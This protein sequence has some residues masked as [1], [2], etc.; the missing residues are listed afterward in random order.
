MREAGDSGKKMDKM[1]STT[2]V[3]RDPWGLRGARD[4]KSWI[5]N[6]GHMH[7]EW[8]FV[9]L[10]PGYVADRGMRLRV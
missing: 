10:A 5:Y 6:M 1:M 8:S 4:P 3:L 2:E 7:N 9:C